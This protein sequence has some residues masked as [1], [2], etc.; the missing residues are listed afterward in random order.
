MVAGRPIREWALHCLVELAGNGASLEEL[1]AFCEKTGIPGRRKQYWG[2]SAWHALLRPHVLMQYCG[3]AVWNV[4]TKAGWERPPEDWVIAERGH[5]A[6][7]TEEEAR[8]IAEARRSFGGKKQFNAGASRSRTSRYLLSG[9]LFR[10]GRCGANMIGFHTDG[11]FYY[12]CGLSEWD[13]LRSGG[14]RTPGA[15]RSPNPA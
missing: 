6:L 14:V 9:G 1:R 5:E 15:G 4:H 3:Y 11:R 10:C 12:V 7:I 8:R 2:I 13:G